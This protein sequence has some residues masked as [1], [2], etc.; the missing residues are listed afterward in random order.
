M[1]D[2]AS[3]RQGALGA[4]DRLF[5]VV[6]ALKGLDGVLEVLGGLLLLVVRPEQITG[7]AWLLTRHELSEDPNDVVA[8]LVLH[9]SATLTTGSGALLGAL[10]LLSHGLVKVVLVWAVL[11]N[12]LWAYPW[13][14][15][16]LGIFLL[17]QAY[18]LALRFSLGLALLSA[19]DLL[20]I[21][22]TV[23][24]YRRNRRRAREGEPVRS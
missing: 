9:G 14:I 5:Q 1:R 20:V 21:W 17:Y 24:E 4:E 11:R 7:L 12:K 8:N 23:R 15:A 3:R 18:R 22:L 6:I 19:F 10:Y 13:M 2:P 16:F